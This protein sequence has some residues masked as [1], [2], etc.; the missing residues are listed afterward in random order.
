MNIYAQTG[1]R[2]RCNTLDAGYEFDRKIAKEHLEVGKEY[3]V[4]YT[5]VDC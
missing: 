3:T 5:N 1:H 2:V 4:N